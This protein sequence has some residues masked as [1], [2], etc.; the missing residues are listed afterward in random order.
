MIEIM[1]VVSILGVLAALAAPSFKPTIEKWRVRDAA[2]ALQSTI[3][4]ARSEAIKRGGNVTILKTSSGNGCTA[5]DAATQ[6]GCGWTVFADDNNNGALDATESTLKIIAPPLRVEIDVAASS[7][8]ITLDRWGQLRSNSSSSFDFRL[9][10]Q[11]TSRTH[12]GA[13]AIC[14]SLGGRVNRLGNGDA[15]CPA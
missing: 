14:I 2:E 9:M 13:T 12:T 4:Y 1:I 5:A 15:A 3:F 10:P 11:G 8:F 7:G 6:W